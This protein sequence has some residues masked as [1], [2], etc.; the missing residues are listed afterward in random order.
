LI[1]GACRP[2]GRTQ[3][4][5]LFVGQSEASTGATFFLFFLASLE[6]LSI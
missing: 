1:D 4:P 3:R 6:T 2:D 5:E